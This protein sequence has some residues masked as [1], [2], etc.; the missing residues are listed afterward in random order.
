MGTNTR[1]VMNYLDYAITE[2]YKEIDFQLIDLAEHD[3]QFSDGRHFMTYEGDTDFVI[4]SIMEADALIIGTP[5]IQASI[6]AALKN[7]FDL[8]PPDAFEDKIVSIYVTA[9][10]SRHYLVAEQH[11]KPILTY[12]RARMLQSYVFIEKDAFHKNEIIDAD[13][14]YR[15]NRLVQET[16]KEIKKNQY[17]LDENL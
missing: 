16:L 1:T 15:L 8:L 14:S 7:V 3:I 9:G 17:A 11:L 2:T 10:S 4:K 6:P 12:M 5:I 13:V